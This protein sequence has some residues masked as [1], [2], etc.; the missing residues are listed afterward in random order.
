VHNLRSL[1]W[2]PT[3]AKG[4]KDFMRRKTVCFVLPTV[5]FIL[6]PSAIGQTS[7]Q[8]AIHAGHV[9]EVKSGKML[10]DQMLVIED[11]K[12]VSINSAAGTKVASDTV[13]IDLPNATLLPGFIDAHTHLT[14]DPKFGYETLALSTSRQA[15]IGARNARLTLLAGFTTVRNVG[16]K[17]F[18]DVAL[19]DAINAGDVPG[20]RMLVSGPPLSITGGHC[21]NNM[22][23]FE[24][25]ASNDG[26]ADGLA[27]V[28]HKVRENI[29]YGADLIKVCATG[30]VLSLGDNPQHSQ[31]TLEEM[32]AIVADAH[33]LGRKV[34]AHAHGAEGIRWAAEAGV[35]SVEHGSYIDD[36][37][38]AAMKEHGTYLVPTLYL[39]DWMID[40]AGLTHLPPPLLAKAREVIPAARKNIA[41]ALVAGVKVALGTDAAVYPH[42]L[43]AHEF[44]VMARLGL[45]PLQSIQAGT[46]NAADLLGWSGKVG[47]LEPGAWAD[48]VAVDGDPL[49]D[50]TT[51]ARVKFVMK[52]GEVVKNEYTK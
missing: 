45:T 52:G 8:V 17:D 4:K 38:I 41:R 43:N 5:L 12:I 21:D 16:A 11:G 29:K 9:L 27:A 26:V 25:H 28:Q 10:S 44:E 40:N 49:K 14:M 34:A 19:R 13:R 23:P 46:L 24:Y 51:L 30:G 48:I 20:P 35:D 31:Y 18:S 22:L 36:A 1:L 15:L 6:M 32:K 37:G 3:L 33:R 50:I 2:F 7:R 39:G 47:T 42:G